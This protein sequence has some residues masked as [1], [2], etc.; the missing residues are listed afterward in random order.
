[1]SGCVSFANFLVPSSPRS[2]NNR[3]SPPVPV[4]VENETMTQTISHDPGVR[5]LF[6]SSFGN[7]DNTPKDVLK[8]IRLLKPMRGTAEKLSIYLRSATDISEN[9]L[10]AFSSFRRAMVP[11]LCVRLT[12][13]VED[14]LLKEVPLSWRPTRR[15]NQPYPQWRKYALGSFCSLSLRIFLTN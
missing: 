3:P 12:Y 10:G 13:F 5:S 2:G 7:P 8:D 14:L 9:D 6:T 4:S 15:E 11:F 1:M